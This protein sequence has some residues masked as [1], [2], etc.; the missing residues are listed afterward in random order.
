M[1]GAGYF[2]QFQA[3]GWN[4]IPAAK[5][6]AVTD[7]LPGR[8]KEFAERWKIP[9]AYTDAATMLEKEKP[10]FVDI[11]TRPE[12]HLELVTLAARHGVHAICQ[13]PMAPT[14]DE[15]L[16]MVKVCQESKVRLL[17]HENW[18]WQPW[19]REIKRLLEGGA[20]GN[21]FHIAFQM[22]TGDGRGDQPYTLQPY[23]REMPRFILYE[24][25]VHFIDTFRYLVGEIAAV[26]SQ[27]GRVNP[28][29][30]GED[31]A[32]VQIHFHGGVHGLIDANRFSGRIPVDVTLGTFRLEGDR[33][34]IRLSPDGQLWLT[35][36]GKDEVRHAFP[37]TEIGYKGDSV[38]A[39]QEHLVNCLQSGRRSEAEGEDY[40]KNVATVFACYRSAETG[41]TV[42]PDE[43][44]LR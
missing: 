43:W 42:S 29:I 34:A 36:Y 6:V 16:A 30:K 32:L 1:I 37:T 35:E 11:A 25:V 31:Y 5:I 17:M 28:L 7:A 40:L 21:P 4:R 39:T 14:W 12:A 24:V 18:R 44:F 22:R 3:E 10:D 13:K 20:F 33:A 23:F 27:I 2:A 19:Y 41:R 9:F 15:C 38:K 26:S 8:A